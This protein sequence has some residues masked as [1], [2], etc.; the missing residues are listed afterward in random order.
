VNSLLIVLR[1]IG[2]SSSVAT[3]ETALNTGLR[4]D[5]LIA[6]ILVS[7]NIEADFRTVA[8]LCLSAVISRSATWTVHDKNTPVVLRCFPSPPL[9]S[10]DDNQ[11]RTIG[12]FGRL[13]NRYPL[14]GR[15]LLTHCAI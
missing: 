1:H 9:P 13:G 7:H 14:M 5:P 11:E 6:N 3:I 15:A 12:T 8:C 10:N 2:K 4:I